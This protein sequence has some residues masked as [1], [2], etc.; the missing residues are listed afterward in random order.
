M[1]IGERVTIV[2]FATEEGMCACRTNPE[3]GAAQKLARE[4]YYSEYCKASVSRWE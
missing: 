4:K 3:H 2:E 1:R